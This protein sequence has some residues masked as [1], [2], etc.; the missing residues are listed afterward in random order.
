MTLF[1]RFK[2]RSR[3]KLATVLIAA[4]IV[5]A[6][7][8]SAND[9]SPTTTSTTTPLAASSSTAGSTCTT[10][11][12]SVRQSLNG[13][14]TGCFRVPELHS[15]SVVVALQTYLFSGTA[16]ANASTTTVSP[17]ATLGHMSLSPGS[18]NVTPG[19]ELT[20]TGR[21]LS[22]PPSAQQRQ[23][24]VTVCWDGCQTGLQEQ[25][26]PIHWSSSTTFHV[27]LTV[28]ETA[29]LS[30]R[31]GAV[32][33]HPLE[34]GSYEVGIQCIEATSGCALGPA[35]A[36]ATIQ[37]KA[38]TP[39]RC[40]T[41][42]SCETMT[43]STSKAAP[44]NVIYFK[45]WA[46][47]QTIIG[48][49]TGYQLSLSK[50][51]ARQNYPSLSFT[52]NLNAGTY[53]VV[54]GPRVLQVSPSQTWA[55]LGRVPY[56][57]STYA[58]PSAIQPAGNSNRIAWCPLSGI[59]ITS[60]PV[61]TPVPTSN[62]A[63][64]LRGTNLSL[65]SP[66]STNPPCSAV[67]LDPRFPSSVYATFDTDVS[68]SAPPIYF[69]GLYTTNK[70]ITW[71]NVPTPPR[72]SLDDFGGFITNGNQVEALFAS[73]SANNS[74]FPPGTS[75]GLVSTEV[76]S[77]GGATWS[78]STLGCP[79]TGPCTTFGPD[80]WG[81]CAMNASPQSLL[82]GHSGAI[83]R[84]GM[85]WV[86]TFWTP[87]VNSC[88]SPQLAVNSLHDLMLLDPS[89]QYPLMRSTNSGQTWT[90]IQLPQFTA[91]DFGPGSIQL[92]NSLLLAP[93]GSLFTVAT[94]ASGGRQG[95]FRLE[96]GATKWCP[97]P[98][99]LDVN[100]SSETIGSLRTSQTDLIWIQTNY[101]NGGNSTSSIHV[102]PLSSLRC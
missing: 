5:L 60:G 53:N 41:G 80:Q 51:S 23:S 50:G 47:L 46:P 17:P 34:S 71:R 99:V 68:H 67:L 83:A 84:S 36:Q 2:N 85:K 54:L 56:L 75:D 96:P 16:P 45:G 9:A 74:S 87:T 72:S 43:L 64:A 49:P 27:S 19:E 14:F 92:G 29:W 7:C 94:A 18:K 102:V 95:L 88:F 31:G 76:T 44:G 61:V 4:G 55:A 66:T 81:H 35:D 86:T 39:A 15:S 70:G 98:K 78:A 79:S 42:Q 40:L 82:Q 28:P 69:A 11:G 65:T 33:A 52:H 91:A 24:Y 6:G 48:Q 58:G 37:L 38:P 10:N 89:S 97:V 8:G 12:G 63:A 90:S 93:N 32:S 57:S 22:H 21:F 1:S 26:A 73:G 62:V 3:M 25:G 59:D 77:N 20:L 101:P 13:D 30:T 100:D